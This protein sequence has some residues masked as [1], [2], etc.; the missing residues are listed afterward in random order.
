VPLLTVSINAEFINQPIPSDSVPGWDSRCFSNSFTIGWFIAY[1]QL[2]FVT[3]R[4][5]SNELSGDKFGRFIIRESIPSN[6]M[7]SPPARLIYVGFDTSMALRNF[8]NASDS[9]LI[10]M[11]SVSRMVQAFR[12]CCNHRV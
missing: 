8:V 9:S 3:G 12:T 11:A 4:L 7:S 5:N 10:Q 6:S 2:V 1:A